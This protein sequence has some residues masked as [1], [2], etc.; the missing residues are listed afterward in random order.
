M[1]GALVY[2]VTFRGDFYLTFEDI[3]HYKF[4]SCLITLYILNH[5]RNI[6]FDD[7]VEQVP[8]F[9]GLSPLQLQILRPLFMPCDRHTGSIL[10]DQ[11]DPAEYLYL[12]VVGEVTIR[13]KPDDG[14]V[15]LVARIRPGG[16][17]GWS[18]VLGNLVY[19]SGAICSD[20]TQ[21]LRVRGRDLRKLCEDYPDTGA[22]I[23]DR[24]A[25][26]IAERL[27]HTHDQVIE[28][29]K[30]GMRHG[31]PSLKEV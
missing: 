20:D 27:S 14:A 8:L 1:P 19:T 6:M 11:G 22:I 30:Q 15:I 23:L 9:Q 26:I 16:V 2:S 29:L 10:F 28:L 3:C 12:V 5:R 21:M 13:Y 31:T 18:A 24:L 17:V 25:C 4:R 7:I